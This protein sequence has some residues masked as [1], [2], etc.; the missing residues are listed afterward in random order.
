[1]IEAKEISKSFGDKTV[2]H[3]VSCTFE[4]GKTNL[5]IG[6]S[7]SGKTVLL[8]S[9]V[10]LYNVDRGSIFFDGR[11]VTRMSRHARQQ[12]RQE[13]GMIFQGS[14][15][16]DYMTVLENVRFPLDMFTNLSP[17]ER[18]ARAQQ[19]LRRVNLDE[20][21]DNLYPAEISG[22]MQK[23]VAIAR[24]IVQ[25]PRYLFCDEP[26]SGLDPTTAGVIDSLISE[27]THE[28]GITTIINTH[29]MNSVFTIGEHIAFIEG[30]HKLWDGNKDTILN[31][32]CPELRNFMSS[33]VRLMNL[34]K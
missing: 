11:D 6:K 5:I 12:L 18:T 2:M 17:T 15:L 28:S 22:G 9:L 1:M 27:I 26:N 7:G 8:K 31:S 34:N 3:A 10:G 20:Q 24:A 4:A 29:D 30:G 13:V 19:C 32:E 21:A 33:A 25:N 14:A 23:R 16:F